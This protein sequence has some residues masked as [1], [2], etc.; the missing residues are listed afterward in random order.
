MAD[1]NSIKVELLGTSFTLKADTNS[2]HLEQLVKIYTNYV[3]SVKEEHR[4][5]DPLKIAIV[6]GILLAD[7][8]AP[9]F[10]DYN[11]KRDEAEAVKRIT[12]EL[13]KKIDT[14]LIK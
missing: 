7:S 8:R 1:D 9:N 3:N 6:A 2:N 11:F 5:K 12:N 10:D 4:I 13:I 14:C